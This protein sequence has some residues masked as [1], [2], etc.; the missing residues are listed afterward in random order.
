MLFVGWLATLAFMDGAGV[1]T[2]AVQFF[3]GWHAGDAVIPL[4]K[5]VFDK[6]DFGYGQHED[7]GHDR[8]RNE[9]GG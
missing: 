3:G 4:F 6:R 8:H 2:F 1:V 5:G 9:D 7:A